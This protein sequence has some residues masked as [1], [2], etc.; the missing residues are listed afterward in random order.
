MKRKIVI[1]LWIIG[2]VSCFLATLSFPLAGSKTL[3]YCLIYGGLSSLA[4]IALISSLIRIRPSCKKKLMERKVF[5]TVIGLCF[6]FFFLI[7]WSEIFYPHIRVF[8]LL[9][10]SV[11]TTVFFGKFA[12]HDTRGSKIFL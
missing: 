5:I 6:I 1:L 8:R 9:E 10:I 12:E 7:S 3:F 2:L 11:L 4:L